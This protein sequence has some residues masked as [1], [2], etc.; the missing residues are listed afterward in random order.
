MLFHMPQKV[1]PQFPF[2]LNRSP[3][4]YV[5]EFIFLGL[6]LDCNIVFKSHLKTIETKIS[7]VIVLLHKLKYLFFAYLLRMI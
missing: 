3:I 4:D 5:T 2:Y 7:K 6:T 1:V